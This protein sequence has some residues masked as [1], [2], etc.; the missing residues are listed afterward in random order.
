MTKAQWLAAREAELLPVAYFHFVFTLPHELNAPLL[1]DPRRVLS[2]LFSAASRTLLEFGQQHLHGR[3][4]FTMVLHTWD[5][6][7]NLH[8][9]VHVMMPAGALAD[10]GQR[11]IAMDR[12]FAFP[13]RA[14]SQVF[15]GKFMAQAKPW[16]DDPARVEALY[17][18][19]WVVYA[20]PPF[21][22]ARHLLGYLGR[23]THRVGISNDRIQA[24]DGE[25]VVFTY[26][27][28]RD[29]DRLKPMA[30]DG[31]EFLRRFLLHV[32]PSGFMRVRHYGLLANRCKKQTLARCRQLLEPAGQDRDPAPLPSTADAVPLPGDDPTVRCPVCGVVMRITRLA[33]MPR[34]RSPR[35]LHPAR[36][37]PPPRWALQP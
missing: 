20:Q 25:R 1:A 32:L 13:V 8:P 17:G 33:P 36:S 5:R 30:L 23:Y 22:G 12:K 21:G 18:K 4:G 6:R 9:H 27:D 24:I 2:L 35:R 29:G 26:R 37:P 11:W 14:L 7:L 3:V 31:V 16:L 19:P 34:P 28:R 10:D 15:R